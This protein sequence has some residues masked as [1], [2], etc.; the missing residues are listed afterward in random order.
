MHVV[1]FQKKSEIKFGRGHESEIRV[2]DISVSR[3]H[4][5]IVHQS[6]KFYLRDENSK[7]GTLM[8]LDRP[9]LLEQHHS[10]QVRNTVIE[11]EIPEKQKG[12]C[13]KRKPKVDIEP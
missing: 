10:V 1:N 12:K 4:A 8:S 13:C 3:I 11:L 2:T 7:F 5:T 9:R 6:G